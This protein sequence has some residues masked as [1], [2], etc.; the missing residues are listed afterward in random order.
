MPAL[1]LPASYD[2]ERRRKRHRAMEV[3]AE[4]MIFLIQP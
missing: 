3:M 2:H 4:D 1:L